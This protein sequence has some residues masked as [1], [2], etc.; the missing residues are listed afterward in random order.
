MSAAAGRL[1][2]YGPELILLLAFAA[3]R[4]AARLVFGLRFDA[5]VRHYWHVLD[6]PLLA[7]DLLRSLFY[8]HDQPPLYNLAIGAVLKWVPEPFGPR[9]WEAALLAA[10]YLGIVAIYAL[11]VEL[12]APRGAAL[13]AALVQTLSTTWLVYES[14]LFYTLPVAVLMTW[15][16]VWLA[17]AARGSA[18]GFRRALASA[19]SRSKSRMSHCTRLVSRNSSTSN[20][21]MRLPAARATWGCCRKP[22]RVKRSRSPKPRLRSARCRS[23]K[24]F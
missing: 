11:L 8:L 23:R 10:S 21:S 22:S 12:G 4:L 3:T 13:A 14:W 7:N 6:Y 16:A 18:P 9:V 2:R 17:R 1:F 5:D 20:S 15:A 24:R 19:R